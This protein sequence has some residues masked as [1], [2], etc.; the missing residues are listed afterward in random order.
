MPVDLL[1]GWAMWGPLGVLG[2]RWI[3]VVGVAVVLVAGRSGADASV[4]AGGAAWAAMAGGEAAVIALCLVPGLVFA[5]WTERGVWLGCRVVMQFV[6]FS[7]L[8][9]LLIPAMV[10]EMGLGVLPGWSQWD[11][12]WIQVIIVMALPGVSALEEFVRR[13][14]GTPFPMIRR[15]GWW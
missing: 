6:A 9:I 15:G 13:G 8:L 11:M 5:R 7:G 2:A 14:G 3:G 10:I 4:C 1:L 12:I